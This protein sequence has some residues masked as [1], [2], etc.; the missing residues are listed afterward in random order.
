MAIAVAR[1]QRGHGT[2]LGS[3]HAPAQHRKAHIAEPWLFLPVDSHVIAVNIVGNLFFDRGIELIAKPAV[4][5]GQKG[6]GSPAFA[7]KQMLHARPVAAFAQALLIAEELGDL[8]HHRGDLVL[9][10]E[11]IQANPQMRISRET[12]AHADRKSHLRSRD[13]AGVRPMS[14]IS[15]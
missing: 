15:G 9:L 8:T 6:L 3:G 13:T 4:Q 11:R 10:H 1:R 14:L 2:Q 12:A 7:K 5:V